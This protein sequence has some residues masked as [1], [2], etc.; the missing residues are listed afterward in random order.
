MEDV[1]DTMIEPAAI[2]AR[3][4]GYARPVV[5]AY[6]NGGV[7]DKLLTLPAMHALAA[8]FGERLV[9][10]CDRFSKAYIYAGL[11]P[12]TLVELSPRADGS[13]LDLFKLADA[14]DECDLLLCLNTGVHRD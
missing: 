6:D 3:A 8:L 12:C 7:G 14:I 11:Q 5:L 13:G 1:M 4:L 2:D 9:I 10:A